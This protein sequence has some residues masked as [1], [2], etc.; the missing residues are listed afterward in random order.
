M[1]LRHTFPDR[2]RYLLFSGMRW[3]H[4]GHAHSREW[5]NKAPGEG[6]P[7]WAPHP[8]VTPEDIEAGVGREL[9]GMEQFARAFRTVFGLGGSYCSSS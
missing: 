4:T 9:A 6:P 8:A 5:S 2:S 1:H 3:F 7:P